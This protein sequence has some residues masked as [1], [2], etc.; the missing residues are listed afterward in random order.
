MKRTIV[1]VLS[2]LSLLV[3]S[4]GSVAAYDLPPDCTPQMDFNIVDE[5]VIM[6]PKISTDCHLFW[7]IPIIHPYELTEVEVHLIHEEYVDGLW[8][9]GPKSQSFYHSNLE[10]GELT[11]VLTQSYWNVES[12]VFINNYMTNDNRYRMVVVVELAHEDATQELGYQIVDHVLVSD[13]LYGPVDPGPT[14]STIEVNDNFEGIPD[15][16]VPETSDDDTLEGTIQK[17][18]ATD[19]KTGK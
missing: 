4:V 7:S 6:Y 13:W 15:G 9:A 16:Y 5:A 14:R 2:L 1:M 3:A 19:L 12:G 17:T 18:S 10:I 11:N 8:Q